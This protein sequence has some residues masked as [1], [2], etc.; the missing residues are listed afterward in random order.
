MF[1]V[2]VIVSTFVIENDELKT[3]DVL[4]VPTQFSNCNIG[5][6]PVLLNFKFE[7][8]VNQLLRIN[9]FLDFIHNLTL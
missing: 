8:N 4:C 2:F 5:Y 6:V 7:M 1:T 3:F 9:R